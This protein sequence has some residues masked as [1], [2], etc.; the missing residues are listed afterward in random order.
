[1]R[2]KNNTSGIITN[3]KQKEVYITIPRECSRSVMVKTLDCGIVVGEFELQFRY[4]VNFRK[5]TLDK[6]MKPLILPVMA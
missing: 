5:N 2:N 3:H 6:G 4:Y 1:M